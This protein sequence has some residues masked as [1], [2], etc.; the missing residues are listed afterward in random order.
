MVGKFWLKLGKL[1]GH[2]VIDFSPMQQDERATTTAA[3]AAAVAAAA[4]ARL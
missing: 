2:L 3:A 1:P 4:A